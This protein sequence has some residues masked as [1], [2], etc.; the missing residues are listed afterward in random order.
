MTAVALG[1]F[2]A[3]TNYVHAVATL[4]RATMA[5]AIEWSP[6]AFLAGCARTPS[7]RAITRVSKSPFGRHEVIHATFGPP[8]RTA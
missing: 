5:C 3:Y 6:L 7:E 1:F 2:D 8:R 4:H